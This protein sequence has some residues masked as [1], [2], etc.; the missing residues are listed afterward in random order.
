MPWLNA[1]RELAQHL[2]ASRESFWLKHT[3]RASL[4]RATVAVACLPGV[5]CGLFIQQQSLLF[6]RE[7]Q[8]QLKRVIVDVVDV[9]LDVAAGP[10]RRRRLLRRQG[11][12]RARRRNLHVAEL[13]EE[14]VVLR[15]R[16]ERES[17]R[18]NVCSGFWFF[19]CVSVLQW[20]LR[21]HSSPR[22]PPTWLAS[23]G[24]AWGASACRGHSRIWCQRRSVALKARTLP[25]LHS[26]ASS[27]GPET[28][29]GKTRKQ[30]S[31]VLHLSTSSHG[32]EQQRWHLPKAV[33]PNP[34]L[35]GRTSQGIHIPVL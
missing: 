35:S 21:F 5:S 13:A 26:R 3:Q 18:F 32:P 24:W 8:V 28:V 30:M 9:L 22:H 29:S 2:K 25:S 31:C 14:V 10:L 15:Q 23:K 12:W 1:N 19:V 16:D 17:C 4:S 6:V 7:L 33:W 27:W 11:V 20:Y 34:W